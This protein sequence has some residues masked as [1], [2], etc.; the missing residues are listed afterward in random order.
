MVPV[1]ERSRKLLTDRAK[2]AGAA[3]PTAAAQAALPPA[4]I[5]RL[6]QAVQSVGSG[7]KP[8]PGIVAAAAFGEGE[9]EVCRGARARVAWY[10]RLNL[11]LAIGLIVIFLGGAGGAVVSG[12]VKGVSAWAAVFGGV[13]LASVFG[14][15]VA[16]PLKMVKEAIVASTRLDLLQFRW[17]QLSQDCAGLGTLGEQVDCRSQAWETVIKELNAVVQE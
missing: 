3:G 13:S 15:F 16:R 12:I 11:V 14:L 5:A 10:F 1:A 2:S 9:E 7:G 4:F 8:P 17:V 6:E